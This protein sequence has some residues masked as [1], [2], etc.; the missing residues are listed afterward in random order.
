MISADAEQRFFIQGATEH[1][2][3]IEFNKP[4]LVLDD[5]LDYFYKLI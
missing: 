5:T 1:A 3:Q 4:Y 2:Y